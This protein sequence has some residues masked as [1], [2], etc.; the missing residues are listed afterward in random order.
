M[1]EDQANGGPGNRLKAYKYNKLDCKE[2]RKMREEEGIQ[3]RK[4]K[5]DLLISKK[6]NV[7][8]SGEQQLSDDNNRSPLQDALAVSSTPCV[9]QEMIQALYSDSE[10]AQHMATQTF[11]KLLSKEPN[12]PIDDIVQTGI[13][14]RFVQLLL[15]H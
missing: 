8:V 11:R 15:Q 12:P 2:I 14:P 13:V 4:Q 1:E 10:E 7:D 9:T 6:R 3:L 5:K